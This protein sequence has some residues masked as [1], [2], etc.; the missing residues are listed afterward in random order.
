MP[1]FREA[2][3]NRAIGHGEPDTKPKPVA[4]LVAHANFK[5]D[6]V[7][8][9]DPRANYLRAVSKPNPGVDPIADLVADHFR[10]NPITDPAF[11]PIVDTKPGPIPVSGSYPIADPSANDLRSH[12]WPNAGPIQFA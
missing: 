8:G 7:G 12:P 10:A 9:S 3:G 5:P 6:P 2:D 1:V 11:N 4:D